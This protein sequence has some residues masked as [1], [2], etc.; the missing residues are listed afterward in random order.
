MELVYWR[1]IEEKECRSCSKIHEFMTVGCV[2]VA[3]DKTLFRNEDI[4][5]DEY[6]EVPVRLS[7]LTTQNIEVVESDGEVS[8]NETFESKL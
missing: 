6:P 2:P 1:N 4:S 3:W 5:E 7:S 8:E